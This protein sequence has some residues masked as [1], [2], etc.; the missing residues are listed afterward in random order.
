MANSKYKATYD[1]ASWRLVI[2]GLV[3]GASNMAIEEAIHEAVAGNQSP[4]TLRFSGWKPGYLSLG[5]EQAW[6]IVDED[7][8]QRNGWDVVRRPTRGRAILQ[9]DGLSVSVTI[10]STDPRV[11]GDDSE[12]FSCVSSSFVAALKAMGLDPD[13]SR[14][15]YQDHGPLGLACFDG[16]SDYQITIG[17]R[18]LV[19]GTVWSTKDAVSLQCTVLLFGETRQIADTLRFDMP[20]QRMALMAR[21]GYRAT[22]LES[23]FGRRVEFE[24]ATNTLREGFAKAQNITFSAGEL[25][26]A[27]STRASSLRIQKYAN[28]DWTKGIQPS[29]N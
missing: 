16:P 25:T 9:V 1:K 13:R 23:V 3:D 6:E 21:I 5:L 20:G 10:P 14:P 27:E 2:S 8:C 22:T 11:I 7:G 19:C 17:G 12:K 24:E 4:A 26:E 15:Y 29:D 18:K 28:D